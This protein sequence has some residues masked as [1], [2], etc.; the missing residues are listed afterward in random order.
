MRT[1]LTV[2]A[3]D[4]D[5]GRPATYF[6]I[7]A[8]HFVAVEQ[9]LAQCEQAMQSVAET[10]RTALPRRKL[11]LY[12]KRTKYTKRPRGLYWGRAIKHAK[13]HHLP[14]RVNLT[15]IYFVGGNED[16]RDAYRLF[17]DRAA[18]L[19]NAH[20]LLATTSANLR[21]MMSKRTF[22]APAWPLDL[23]LVPSEFGRAGFPHA[24]PIWAHCSAIASCVGRLVCL[25]SRFAAEGDSGFVLTFERDVD[26]P[27]GRL[28]WRSA[29]GAH[30]PTPLRWYRLERARVDRTTSRTLFVFER[31]RR[32]LAREHHQLTAIFRRYTAFAAGAVDRAG[33]LIAHGL[34]PVRADIPI[35]GYLRPS[36]SLS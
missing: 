29:S 28:R 13:R 21:S 5:L 14:G 36:G 30:L 18:S 11:V 31:E 3:A 15:Y 19:N 6:R 24:L 7:L 27:F 4:V 1:P 34:Q 25:A 32:L 26:H 23:A 35:G 20:K 16:Y 8:D 33:A 9:M 10:F 12:V 2:P 22:P 17:D